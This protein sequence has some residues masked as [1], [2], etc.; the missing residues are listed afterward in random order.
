LHLI[1]GLSDGLRL[2]DL[3]KEL[4][5]VLVTKELLHPLVLAS[6]GLYNK[7]PIFW[8]HAQHST[9]K[10][11]RCE[12]GTSKN[13]QDEEGKDKDE[14]GEGKTSKVVTMELSASCSS[15]EPRP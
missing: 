1:D 6:E 7:S 2:G 14:K 15:P 10:Q 3:S 11:K 12:E 4:D 13:V 5:V 8:V 9:E